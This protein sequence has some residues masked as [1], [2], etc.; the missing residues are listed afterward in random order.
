MTRATTWIPDRETALRQLAAFAP[1]VPRYAAE[2]NHAVPGDP[3]VSRLSPFIRYRIISEEEVVR[4][5]LAACPFAVAEKFV[6]EV[7]WRAHWKGSLH[8]NPSPWLAYRERLPALLADGEHAAWGDLHRRALEG[9]TDL[10]CFND[11]VRELTATGFLHNHVRMWFASIWI[12]TFRI[13]WQLGA[14][15]MHHHLLDGDPASNTLS[16]RWVAGLQTKGKRYLAKADNIETFSAGRWKPSAAE[17]ASESFPIP[18]DPWHGPSLPPLRPTPG[19]RA[20]GRG[21]LLSCDDLSYDRLDDLST[22]QS[23][24]VLTAGE[25][26]TPLKQSFLSCAVED[27]R[28]RI[29]AQAGIRSF[30]VATSSAEIVAW[31]RDAELAHVTVNPPQVGELLPVVQ[32]ALAGLR[33]RPV[34]VALSRRRWDTEIHPLCDKGFFVTWE[35]W[36]KRFERGLELGGLVSTD[37]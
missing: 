19:T 11:W 35:R 36:K 32:E 3:A 16:W 6:Q 21:L 34:S 25:P 9:R 14:A 22:Y 4:A 23:V 7:L 5:A 15:F 27:L 33:S 10:S 26:L 24:C 8:L 29:G 18:D 17:L 30:T 20:G 12:F 13:P 37:W 28:A 31:V 2:R 1:L